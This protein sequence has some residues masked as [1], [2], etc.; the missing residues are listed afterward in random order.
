MKN[1]LDMISLYEVK[2]KYLSESLPLV[3]DEINEAI[4]HLE[5]AKEKLI[6]NNKATGQE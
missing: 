4:S 6:L 2:L 1:W 5:K 3:Q